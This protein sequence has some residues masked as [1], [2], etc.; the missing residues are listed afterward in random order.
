M[1]GKDPR[2]A[3]F[4]AATARPI[5]PQDLEGTSKGPSIEI[6]VVDH[7]TG[8]PVP[9]VAL[10]RAGWMPSKPVMTDDDGR[11]V[12]PLSRPLSDLLSV[13]VRKD[14]IAPVKL[15]FPSPVR[16]EEIPPSYTLKVYPSETIGGA[17]RDEQGRPIAGVR[18]TPTV[19]TNS[20]EILYL[21]EDIGD[22]TP[23]MTDAEGRWE[24]PGMPAG[25]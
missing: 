2:L 24:C 5:K 6:R 10:G 4:P 9:G 12:V 16:E 19:W 25:I 1:V 7:R 23:A 22:P 3:V 15:W 13:A 18:V 11:A 21:R 20:S 14:G 17:V 8:R